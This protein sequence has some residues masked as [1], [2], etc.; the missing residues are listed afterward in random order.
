[1]HCQT[2]SNQMYTVGALAVAIAAAA[3]QAE[4]GGNLYNHNN[5]DQLPMIIPSKETTVTLSLGGSDDEDHEEDVAERRMTK[6]RARNR[7][8]ARK[9]R[10]RKKAQL[11][12]LQGK[13]ESLQAESKALKQSLLE[14][15]IA[16][17][18]LG[19]S[20]GGQDG[21]IQTRLKD[22]CNPEDVET[23]LPAPVG[24]KRKRFVPDDVSEKQA[25]PLRLK[26]G[27]HTHMIGGGRANINW[28]S[29]VYS[30]DNG[31]QKQL[32]QKQLGS[33]R[34]VLECKPSRGQA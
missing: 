13:V 32:T 20:S 12:Q 8:H 34:Y 10:L 5:A 29:G 11:E 25:Q 33:L 17:I 24:V 6:S 9:T 7:E 21:R 27:G 19:L 14:C 26:I 15:S 18:L 4:D 16:S 31:V 2:T 1:M 22:A 30:D 3:E 23:S 28:K